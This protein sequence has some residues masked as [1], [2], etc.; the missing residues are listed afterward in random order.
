MKHHT[1]QLHTEDGEQIRF[2]CAEEEDVITAGL[3]NRVI[4]MSECRKG[5]C[6]TCRALCTEGE[7]ELGRGVNVYSLPPEDQDEGY[8]LLCQTY[9]RSDLR[10]ELPYGMDRVTF[11]STRPDQEQGLLV[12]VA[13]LRRWTEH[14]VSL[15]LRLLP[16]EN[17]SQCFPF[18]PGQ[19]VNLRVPDSGNWRSYSMASCPGWPKSGRSSGTVIELMIRLLE[20]GSFS[21]YLRSSAKTG[22]R[23]DMRGPFGTFGLHPSDGRPR[24]FVAG[25][26]GLAPLVSMLRSLAL[27]K[28]PTPARLIFGMRDRA[29]FFYEDEIEEIAGELPSLRVDLALE[30]AHPGWK[31]RQGNVVKT[32]EAVLEE[33]GDEPDLYICG[34]APMV[35]SVEGLCQKRRVPPKRIHTEP[36]QATG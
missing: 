23:L 4:L 35:E 26:T 27:K 20:N 32:L 19:Y 25:S 21:R 24:Y 15:G 30:S 6:T 14:V 7:F 2:D 29:H 22:D 1:I 13:S 36:Y 11:G 9:P 17:G 8:T 31:G 16:E 10:V 34:P 33:T 12:E 5:T 28:D 18:Q 3:R